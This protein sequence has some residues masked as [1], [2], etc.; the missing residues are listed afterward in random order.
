[1]NKHYTLNRWRGGNPEARAQALSFAMVQEMDEDMNMNI[2][3]NDKKVEVNMDKSVIVDDDYYEST[4][5]EY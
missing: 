1:M 3:G 5:T 4:S 2:I